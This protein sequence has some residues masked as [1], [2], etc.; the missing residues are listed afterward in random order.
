MAGVWEWE[1]WRALDA[2]L[3]SLKG[4]EVVEEFV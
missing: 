3:E 4:V 2:C 1:P